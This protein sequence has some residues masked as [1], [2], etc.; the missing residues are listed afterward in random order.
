MRFCFDCEAA[1]HKVGRG[2]MCRCRND[3]AEREVENRG[4]ERIRE[5]DQQ[6]R[7]IIEESDFEAKSSLA[8]ARQI[9]NRLRNQ[10]LATL[11]D[12]FEAIAR[13]GRSHRRDLESQKEDEDC[14][15]Y[16]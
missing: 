14:E 2:C 8:V 10:P 7:V 6:E 3:L 12:H 16:R 11:L 5:S 9:V 13:A 1:G 15:N 4:L